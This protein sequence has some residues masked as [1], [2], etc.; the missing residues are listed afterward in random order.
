MRKFLIA[1]ILA[2]VVLGTYFTINPKP[3]NDYDHYLYLAK[4]FLKLEVNLTG[5]AE[6]YHDTVRKNGKTYAPFGP[7]PALLMMPSIMLPKPLSQQEVSII[8]GAVS[9]GLLFVLLNH[10]TT[11]KKALLISIFIAF[12]TVYFWSTVMG[13]V[14]NFAHISAVFFVILALI[15]HFEKNDFL[16]GVFFALAVLSRYPVVGG[17]LFFLLELYKDRP[18]LIKFLVSFALILIPVQFIYNWLRFQNLFEMGYVEIYQRYTTSGFALSPIR[19]F[20]PFGY[21]DPRNFPL[22]LLVFL[23]YPPKIS[24][25]HNL[26]KIAPSAYGMGVLFTSPL[27]LASLLPNL[28]DKLQRNL[29]LGAISIALFD[30]MHYAQGWVQ[31]G[32]RF[33]LDFIIFLALILALKIKAGK[34][35]TLLILWSIAVCTWG[36]IFDLRFGLL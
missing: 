34:I 5:Q 6:F 15:T 31:F 17:G 7:A 24:F 26:L 32:Y 36:I 18:R 12:G 35:T 29:F 25:I 8:L 20:G 11:E 3:K 4:S 2:L 9:I 21:M 30:F 1:S 16:S 27:L 28:K 19:S 13:T 23:L 14:W 33:A 22:H 10:I